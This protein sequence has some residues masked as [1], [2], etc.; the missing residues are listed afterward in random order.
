MASTRR[1]LSPNPQ[2]TALGEDDELL[3]HFADFISNDGGSPAPPLPQQPHRDR[4]SSRALHLVDSAEEDEY[5]VFWRRLNGA[6]QDEFW[7]IEDHIIAHDSC[8]SVGN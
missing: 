6:N 7:G 5:Y 3:S 1:K 8:I 4:C 2:T